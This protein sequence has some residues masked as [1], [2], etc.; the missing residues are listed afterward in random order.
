LKLIIRGDLFA[1]LDFAA[2]YPGLPDLERRTPQFEDQSVCRAKE[3][4]EYPQLA[5]LP[6]LG[7]QEDDRVDL[8][9]NM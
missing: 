1:L 8:Q 3:L 5:E 9:L 6:R 2:P 4:D 7:L